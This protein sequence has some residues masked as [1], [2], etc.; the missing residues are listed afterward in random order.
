MSLSD[1]I[2]WAY[3]LQSWQIAGGPSWAGVERDTLGPSTKRFDVTAKSEGEVP[4]SPGEFREMLR[5]LQ[6]RAVVSE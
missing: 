3:D 1:L 2:G 5:V 6:I 4:H